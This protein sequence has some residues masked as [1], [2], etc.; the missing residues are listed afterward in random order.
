MKNSLRF[1]AVL[2]IVA[3]AGIQAASKSST[4]TGAGTN[5]FLTIPVKIQQI[6]AINTG[7]QAVTLTF[8]DAASTNL[9]FTN[10]SYTT[11][12]PTVSWFTNMYT[13]TLGLGL[14]VSN[15]Y[16]VV[17]NVSTTVAAST[18]NY[19]V[20]L[21]ILVPTNTPVTYA[22]IGGITANRGILLTNKDSVTISVDYRPY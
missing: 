9:T 15:A 10:A 13:N 16:Q 6:L 8:I 17:S 18:N 19:P 4:I 2:S 11:Y 20:L 1:A 21:S 12:V 5:S 22:P 3:A 14:T 7:T